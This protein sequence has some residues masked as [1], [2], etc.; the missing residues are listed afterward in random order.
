MLQW[1]LKLNSVKSTA[2][3][4]GQEAIFAFERAKPHFDLIFMDNTMPVMVKYFNPCYKFSF[5][6]FILNL[7]FIIKSGLDAVRYIRDRNFDGVVV[8][9]TG[10]AMPSEVQEF[11]AEGA[12]LVVTSK[13]IPAKIYIFSIRFVI[14]PTLCSL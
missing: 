13:F 8:A 2:A 1:L 12:D 6:R 10:N 7:L 9:V 11:L 4:N 5:M 3:R 14:K